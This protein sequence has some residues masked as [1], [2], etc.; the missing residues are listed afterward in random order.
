[1]DPV[2]DLVAAGLILPTPV[3]MLR[4]AFRDLL[5][6]VP[7]PSVTEPTHVA[8]ADVRTG[9]GLPQPT[10]RIGKLGRKEYLELDFV[11]GNRRAIRAQ[12]C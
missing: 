9:F 1:M 6:G 5:E 10:T 11:V 12:P 7:D 4:K 2:L 8:I 3:R